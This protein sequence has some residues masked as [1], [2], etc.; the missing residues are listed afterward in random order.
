MKYETQLVDIENEV[1]QDCYNRGY[2]QGRKDEAAEILQGF[3]KWIKQAISDS[4]DKSVNGSVRD[5]GRN[6]AFHEVKDCLEKVAEF[7]GVEVE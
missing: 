4:Y 7:K 5:G 1:R 6:I 3:Y 2:E